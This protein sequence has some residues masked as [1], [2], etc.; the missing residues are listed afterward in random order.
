MQTVCCGAGS[1][2]CCQPGQTLPAT[3]SDAQQ[4]GVAQ[5]LADDAGNAA[6]MAHG[7]QEEDQVHLGSVDLVVVIE[8][9]RQDV[10]QLNIEWDRGCKED[11]ER[12]PYTNMYVRTM[13]RLHVLL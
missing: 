8:V 4:Q 2:V 9:I 1:H 12:L 11:E 3:A 5:G 7:I 10:Q 13:K 6:D